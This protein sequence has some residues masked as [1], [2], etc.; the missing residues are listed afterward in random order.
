MKPVYSYSPASG[1]QVHPV[2]EHRR[3]QIVIQPRA[4]SIF[5]MLL[6]TVELDRSGHYFTTA[7]RA[8]SAFIAKA[9]AALADK[10]RAQ[11]HDGWREALHAARSFLCQKRTAR[12]SIHQKESTR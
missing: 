11:S 10:T 6:A 12:A 7:D 2:V 4:Q 8:I 3:G 5:T 9:E 1:V